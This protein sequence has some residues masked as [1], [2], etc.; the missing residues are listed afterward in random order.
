MN[1]SSFRKTLSLCAGLAVLSL[2]GSNA[3]A[4]GRVDTLLPKMP[5]PINNLASDG[6]QVRFLGKD[7]GVD[8]WI[9]IKNGQEQYFYVL[10]NGNFLSG[11]LFNPK[12]KA[13]TVEQVSRLRSQSGELL[14]ALT[15]DRPL[16]N[17]HAQEAAKADKYEFKTPSEQ[18]YYD[19]E[20][21]NWLPV[22]QA[23]TPLFYSFTDTQCAH[24]H[25]M[26]N[27]LKS[28]IDNGKVQVRMIPVG[29]RDETQA[30]AAYL[31]AAPSPIDLYW[32]HLNGDKDAIPASPEISKQGVQRNLAIMQ[33]WKLN[34]TPLVIYRG[35]DGKVKIIR[36][37]P[38]NLDGLIADLG[39]RT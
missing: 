32:R 11:L 38:K 18:L 13:I 4:Q 24:C 34:V 37:M 39:A 36:G 9:A 10:P 3:L 2:A 21:S 15:A 26:M 20:N 33:S 35:K 17:A 22:G 27:A 6:A 25:N 14:D 5:D 8:G 1:Y 12:G 28:R 16:Q 19:I 29:F 7:A 23:G 30:Q 31:L